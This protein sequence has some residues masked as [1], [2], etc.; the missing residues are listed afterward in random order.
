MPAF[1]A[2]LI[3]VSV[4]F[5]AFLKLS[6]VCFYSCSSSPCSQQRFQ[7]VSLLMFVI[8]LANEVQTSAFEVQSS[9]SLSCCQ[10]GVSPCTLAAAYTYAS[11]FDT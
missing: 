8:N 7:P 10:R 1:T 9:F 5:C 3:S 4:R 11:T 2:L 6:N